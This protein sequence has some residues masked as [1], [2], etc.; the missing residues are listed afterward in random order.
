MRS[1]IA[2]FLMFV[3]GVAHAAEKP[4]IIYILCDDLGYGDLQ[5]LNPE[6]KIATPNFDSVAAQGRIFTDVHSGSA[7]CSPTRYGVL[8]GRYAWRTPLQRG[9][10][11]GLS[12]RLIEEGRLTAASLLK[13]HG[14]HTAAIGKWHL[15]MDWVKKP[16][17]SVSELSVETPAEVWNVEFDKPFRRGPTSVGFDYYYGISASLDMVPFTFLE[18]DHVTEQP[19]VERIFPLM[20]GRTTGTT[21]VGPGTP[22]FTTESVLP[23]LTEKAVEYISQRASDAK[24]GKPFFLYLPLASPHTPIAPTAE[25]LGKSG[26]NPYADFV[27]QT[28]ATIGQVLQ[29]LDKNGLTENTLLIITS[30]NGCS[31]QA[32]FEE[33][34]PNGHNPSY[35]FRG[36]KADIY[37]GGHRIPFLV[38]WPGHA[39]ANS[40]SDQTLCLTDFLATAAEVVGAKLP[41]DAGEDSVSFLPALLGKADKPLREATVHH[42]ITGAFAVRQGPWKLCFCPDSAGWSTP[43]P[44]RD[45]TSELPRVQLFN[46]ADDIGEK[47]NVQAR[48][49][50][51]IKRLTELMARYVSNGRSTP[52][53]QQKNAVEINFHS[54]EKSTPVAGKA[55]KG[56]AKAKANGSKA[57][58]PL[59]PR[60]PLFEGLGGFGRK[61]ATTSP[62]AQRYFDQGLSFL[63]A[64]NH[65][66]AI[67]SFQQAA[68]FDPTSPLVWGGVAIANGPHINNAMVPPQREKAAWDALAKARQWISKAT[69]VERALID[70]LGKRYADPQPEDRL[71]LDEAYAAAM[72]QVYKT[73]PSDAD[74]GALYAESLMDLRPWDLWTP[75]GKPQP[76]T[77]EIVQTLEAVIEKS[78]KHPLALHLY[79]HAIEASP[80][81]AKAAGAA[82]RLRDLQPGL[83]HHVH[84]P[85]HIDVRFG[86]W[87]KSIEA[88][89]K[90]IVADR[91]YR[92]Q[93]GQQNF[94]RVYMAHNHHMLAYSA[95]MCGQSQLAIDSINEMVA[96]I[97]ADW[98]KENPL[99][100]DGFTAMPLEVLV[101]FGRWDE[102]LAA[103]EP[104]AYLPIA[105]ALRHV[106]RGIAYAVQR[107]I[108]KGKVEQVAFVAAR[109]A[110]PEGAG[111][112]NNLAE[113]LLDIAQHLLAGELLYPEGKVEEAL[114]ELREASRIED[115]LR[116][117]EP[118]DWIHPVRH[119]LG[120]TLLAENRAAEAEAVYREDL[121]RQPNNGW[122]LLGLTRSLKLQRKTAEAEKFDAQF[123]AVWKNADLQINS[124]CF[125][126]PGR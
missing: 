64:F 31:P 106:A 39:T 60:V 111:F 28:D 42:S 2:L 30:D 104:P 69:P 32:K 80:H 57:A 38:R 109:K 74:V 62:D 98:A 92:A 90:A 47:E 75:D 121:R 97:P 103:P 124:S 86:Q 58:S 55:K 25:W 12:P 6:G 45:D 34:V 41:D 123:Q 87:S 113:T 72:R 51:V 59:T 9:V 100:A 68:E 76:G 117:S 56:K 112:G 70:A 27:M 84:M 46:L 26:L 88:N 110:V 91:K 79:I 48:H 16:G 61:M 65:D 23:R 20:S 99:L 21:R 63:Y 95:M 54:G 11:G 101:R 107:D 43:R 119:A 14:Y 115:T 10:L 67:R 52:G 13:Q 3:A 82:D 40:K 44:G 50:E 108:P 81:F 8:T 36:N 4:N 71:P 7:V 126:Q 77:N 1:L 66:E 18:N 105:R 29:A 22:D 93:A 73:Y 85:S 49:P 33:L 78:P 102:V 120:A 122:S 118:P 53:A 94:Y 114:A 116:Y 24:A 17:K 37:E 89:R 35:V 125:C 15:G 96:G 83:G 5:C 19:T